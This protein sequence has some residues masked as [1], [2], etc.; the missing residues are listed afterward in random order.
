[1][2]K[3]TALL[4]II[5]LGSFT[6]ILSGQSITVTK[7]ASG[8]TWYQ[9]QT[10]EIIWT[11]LGNMPDTVKISLKESNSPVI[12]LEIADGVSNSG[13]YSWPIPAS[14]APG[15]YKI[16]VKVKNSTIVDDSGA[17]TIAGA[18]ASITVTKPAAD[19]RWHRS[20]AYAVTWTKMGTMPDSVKIDLYD[21]NGTAVVKPVAAGAPNTGTYSWTVPGDT[22]LGEYRI[23]VKANGANVQGDSGVF[24][25]AL[26][27]MTPGTVATARKAFKKGLVQKITVARKPQITNWL[28]THSFG[29]SNPIPPA[30]WQG[31]PKCDAA[32]N[33]LAEVGAEWFAYDYY[34][35]G[36]LYR[37]RLVF[38]LSDLQG[39]AA[40]LLEAKLK[41]RQ[42]SLVRSGDTNDASCG[43]S[44]CV[45]LAP[46]SSF[47]HIQIDRIGSLHWWKSEYSVDVTETVKKWLNGSLANHGFLLFGAEAATSKNFSCFSCFEASLDLTMK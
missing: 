31:R 46:W 21:K 15:Q 28:G 16:R 2:N 19:E 38:S 35:V 26:V 30:A 18:A 47:D 29:T 25:I 37:S 8:E 13:S 12:V 6:G 24:H 7:P 20:N 45:L 39:Q 9:S 34:R 14:V 36:V 10:R 40:D 22:V 4:F 33:T 42:V 43:Q 27:G 11:K 5:V 3:R 1:M 41:L 32:S 44:L 23:R 17:F